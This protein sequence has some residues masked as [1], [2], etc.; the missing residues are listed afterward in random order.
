MGHDELVQ[1]VHQQIVDY[2]G[3][4]LADIRP[5]SRLVGDLDLDSLDSIELIIELEEKLE[6]LID[7]GEAEHC[8]TVGQLIDYLDRLLKLK[9]KAKEEKSGQTTNG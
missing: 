7:E 3:V 6:V 9:E 2:T 8:Q 4:A 1:I 5:E